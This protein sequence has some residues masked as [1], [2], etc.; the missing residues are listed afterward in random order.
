MEGTGRDVLI[1]ATDEGKI[2]TAGEDIIL[3]VVAREILLL[4][5][6]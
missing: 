1:E 3:I 2:T 4:A 5:T 6:I